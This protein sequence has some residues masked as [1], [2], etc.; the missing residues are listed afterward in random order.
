MSFK[1]FN[2]ESSTMLLLEATAGICIVA[3]IAYLRKRAGP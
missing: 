1:V 3:T 2:C